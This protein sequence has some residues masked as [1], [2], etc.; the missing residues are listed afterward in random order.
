MCLWAFALELPVICV[1]HEQSD[2]PAVVLDHIR[3][4]DQIA[5]HLLHNAGGFARFWF[6]Y[7]LGDQKHRTAIRGYT[8]RRRLKQRVQ[9]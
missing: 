8:E 5:L 3:E 2:K 4:Q 6:L 1:Y 7:W 9:I